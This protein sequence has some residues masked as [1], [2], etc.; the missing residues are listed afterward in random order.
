MKLCNALLETDVFYL[1]C[2]LIVRF[3]F[4]A[5]TLKGRQSNLSPQTRVSKK[6]AYNRVQENF[7]Q[8]KHRLFPDRQRAVAMWLSVYHTERLQQLSK[9]RYRIIVSESEVDRQVRLR[10]PCTTDAKRAAEP[11][12]AHSIRLLRNRRRT[13]ATRAVESQETC[14]VGLLRNGRT[15]VVTRSAE[16]QKHYSEH[17][18]LNQRRPIASQAAEHHEKHAHR[19]LQASHR[20]HLLGQI[21]V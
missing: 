12:E 15:T 17:L 4:S 3:F 5:I 19:L 9:A 8:N 14:P 16:S 20:K 1:I 2:S 7:L 21:A 13:A 10:N 11:R 18:T 6:T